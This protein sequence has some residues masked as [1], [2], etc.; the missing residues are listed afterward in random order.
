MSLTDEFIDDNL[1][2]FRVIA[3]ADAQ[4]VELNY[5]F[6]CEDYSVAIAARFREHKPII[7][8]NEVHNVCYFPNFKI[9]VDCACNVIIYNFKWTS[10]LYTKSEKLYQEN[11]E[12]VKYRLIGENYILTNPQ[13][14]LQY[15]DY[16]H[17][18]SYPYII[19]HISKINEYYSTKAFKAITLV[20]KWHLL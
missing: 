17:Y 10:A 8:A 18:K 5:R 12:E 4:S 2:Y 16:E 1:S 14:L 19:N 9:I 13:T 11:G 6:N 3:R 20:H 7:L 15:K